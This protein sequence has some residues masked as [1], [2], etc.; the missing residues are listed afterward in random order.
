MAR[1]RGVIF[2]IRNVLLQDLGDG[3]GRID[4]H[5]FEETGKLVKYLHANHIQPIVLANHDW[6]V[7]DGAGKRHPLKDV[8]ESEWKGQFEW[9]IA[10]K[11]GPA[12]QT[13]AALEGLRSKLKLAP[14]ET[15]YIGNSETDM[16]SAVNGKTLFLNALWYG[17]TTEYGFR[18]SNPKEVGRFID[19]FC[20][21]EH[22]WYFRIEDGDLRVYSLAPYSTM[23]ADFK[24]Y[25][26]SLIDTVKHKL[27]DKDEID[28]W[29]KYLC[30]STYFS[31]VYETVDYICPYPGHTRGS[32]PRVLEGPMQAFAKCFRKRFIPDLLLR[33]TDAIESKRNRDTVDHLNQLNTI[34]LNQHP[35]KS[36][37]N[38]YASCPVKSGKTVLVV[39]DIL[40]NG[41]SFEAARAFLK[42]AGANVICVSFLK[43][44]KREYRALGSF[45]RFPSTPYDAYSFT[46][47]TIAKQY[48][49]RSNIVD[50]AAP[51]ELS[52]KLEK[53]MAWEWPS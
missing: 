40:S 47:A 49:Y 51:K 7:S 21:R 13:A 33:H 11:D 20:L 37:G 27:G 50:A 30:T 2:G 28:F 1:L 9:C 17:D 42:N 38:A 12:K 8:L 36:P 52:G 23:L 44:M 48:D 43:T 19:T 6:S 53:Y 46:D 18:C 39:D 41:L 22:H 32:V 24:E 15:I 14:N 34:R 25:S 35:E 5:S 10:T 26:E 16:Q 4:G 45:A 31:G 29:G 3:K